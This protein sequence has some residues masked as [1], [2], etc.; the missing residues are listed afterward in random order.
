MC[1]N[2]TDFKWGYL[3]GSW[4]WTVNFCIEY[5]VHK[6]NNGHKHT[7]CYQFLTALPCSISPVCVVPASVWYGFKYSLEVW[8]LCLQGKWNTNWKDT[9]SVCKS[10]FY[11]WRVL[12]I[13]SHES[14]IVLVK[15][16]V[17]WILVFTIVLFSTLTCLP[18]KNA[19]GLSLSL[20]QIPP[21][22]CP[23]EV[24]IPPP[25]SKLLSK[26]LSVFGVES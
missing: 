11:I 26:L 2:C 7:D 15:V 20:Y 3:L 24:C 6:G 25:R 21:S 17:C 23:E 16:V 8:S 13:N 9:R 5:S 1:H 19:N 18:F 22:M 10:G 12:L 4:W 14:Y